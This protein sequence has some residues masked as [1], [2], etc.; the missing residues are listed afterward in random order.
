MKAILFVILFFSISLEAQNAFIDGINETKNVEWKDSKTHFQAFGFKVEFIGTCSAKY[1][2]T[3]MTFENG[4][5]NSYLVET[6]FK[7]IDIASMEIDTIKNI[8]RF[9]SH[10]PM[11]CVKKDVN[12]KIDSNDPDNDILNIYFKN[13][14]M[15]RNAANWALEH[16]KT[17]GGKAFLIN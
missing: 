1:T 6:N 15:C 9:N 14:S 11:P 10:N 7:W 5:E 2:A 17:C 16:I 12:T 4:V 13:T 8:L 3:E